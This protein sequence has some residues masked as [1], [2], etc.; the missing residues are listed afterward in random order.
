[1][2]TVEPPIIPTDDKGPPMPV[3]VRPSI[4]DLRP[5]EQGGVTN[6]IGIGFQDHVGALFCLE[7]LQ[8]PELVEVW[9]ETQD[10]ITL[11]WFLDPDYIVEFVQAKSNELDQLWSSALLCK[12]ENG[13][14]SSL[15]EKSLAY[16]RALQASRFRVVTTRDVKNELRPLRTPLDLSNDV[17]SLCVENTDDDEFREL[18]KDLMGRVGDFVSDNGNDC[19]FWAKN[20]KWNVLHSSEAVRQKAQRK[21]RQFLES[22]QHFLTVD[23]V[24]EL[25]T[26]LANKVRDAGEVKYEDNPDAKKIRKPDL[27]AW[28]NGAVI[29]IMHPA[30]NG[31]GKTMAKKMQA[32]GIPNDTIGLAHELRRLY[33]QERLSPKYLS[34]SDRNRVE[35]ATYSRLI[36]LKAKLDSGELV[37]SGT[38]FHGMCLDELQRLSISFQGIDPAISEAFIQGCMYSVVD[39]CSHRFHRTK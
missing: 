30:E 17:A 7:M 8:I 34:L 9:F 18:I 11:V 27:E 25:Y 5:I 26:Q 16:D 21:L 15:L 14:G 33:R 19:S 12:R 29:K 24:D 22:R 10:D 28:M 39:R 6:R 3:P 13:L 20:A 35:S 36:V 32:A 38:K 23:Q 1:M 31:T 37:A 4:F 2:P